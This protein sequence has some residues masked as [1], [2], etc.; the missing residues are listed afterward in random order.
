MFFRVAS[1]H[2]FVLYVQLTNTMHKFDESLVRQQ[3]NIQ[4][5]VSF[6]N[7]L[8][9]DTIFLSAALAIVVHILTILVDNFEI[10][11]F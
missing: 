4:I 3:R 9:A 1:P 11:R 8:K 6:I 5:N 7:L 2:K 10:L